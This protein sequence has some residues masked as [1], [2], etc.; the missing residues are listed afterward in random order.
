MKQYL[1]IE[2]MTCNGCK[3]QVESLLTTIPAVTHVTV[4]LESKVAAIEASATIAASEVAA[5][6]PAKYTVTPTATP[7]IETDPPADRHSLFPLALVFVY[8]TIAAIGLNY[9][10]WKIASLML[11]FMGIFYA[12]FSF[13]K[14]LDLKGFVQTFRM[15]DPIAKRIP[16]YG[17]IYPFIEVSLAVLFLLRSYQT[18]ALISTIVVLGM[19]TLGVVRVLVAKK[20]IQCACL[21]TAL[22]LPM[23]QATFIENAIMLIM[24][25]SMLWQQ[26]EI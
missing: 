9:R 1:H 7:R 5:V 6:L 11:D 12:V 10:D 24:A 25:I 19:T 22:R 3:H 23:T 20:E 15:Y 18:I 16:I 21:G 17:W 4:D 26:Y 8:I 2:G 14:L 13:F